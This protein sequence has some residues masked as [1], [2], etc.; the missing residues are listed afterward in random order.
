MGRNAG[1]AEFVESSRE[2][3]AGILGQLT[4]RPTVGAG[5]VGAATDT[6][7]RRDPGSK[8]RP[9]RE[10][11]ELAADSLSL[12][13][14]AMR[15]ELLESSLTGASARSSRRQPAVA[16]ELSYEKALRLH[17]RRIAQPLPSP[18][19]LP[20]S[21]SVPD[22]KQ[23]PK[24]AGPPSKPRQ[25]A[26]APRTAT[27]APAPASPPRDYALSAHEQHNAKLA[28]GATA[29][30]SAT[31]RLKPKSRAGTLAGKED[32]LSAE[33]A[34]MP[35]PSKSG[36]TARVTAMKS[37]RPAHSGV[38]VNRHPPLLAQTDNGRSSGL[39]AG[40]PRTSRA[41]EFV[42]DADT[43][44]QSKP[45]KTVPQANLSLVTQRKSIV[46][47]RLTDPEMAM[48]RERA[49]ESE[50]SVSAYMRSC[51]LE[52]ETLRAQVKQAMAEMRSLSATSQ[53]RS[54]PALPE[55][56]DRG[57]EGGAEKVRGFLRSITAFLSPLLIFRRSVS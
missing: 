48:L 2:S 46:S 32:A 20:P 44:V 22:I 9:S 55:A 29:K 23:A 8:G 45:K 42:H 54:F 10:L 19:P 27:P 30:V 39:A 26:A 24:S 12:S 35:H 50:I 47:I 43:T 33:S 56:S 49:D 15:A 38:D 4:G 53:L 34:M 6:D 3:F 1:S 37:R 41:P 11:S 18:S 21:A 40:S 13:A 52:A 28:P 14:R 51:V 7:L 31:S 36:K 17:S 5:V 57:R 25:S 16:T